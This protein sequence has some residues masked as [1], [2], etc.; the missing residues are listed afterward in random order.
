MSGKPNPAA[1]D[2]IAKDLRLFNGENPI[3]NEQI[4]M[5]GDNLETDIKFGNN[6]GFKTLLVLSGVTS[7]ERANLIL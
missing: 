5:V 2:I 1:F 4:L 3:R 7:E 6:L